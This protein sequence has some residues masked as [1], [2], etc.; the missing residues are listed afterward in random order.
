MASCESGRYADH[1]GIMVCFCGAFSL[2]ASI[3]LKVPT[4]L[5][6]ISSLSRII[7]SGVRGVLI[8]VD[9]NSGPELHPGFPVK[10]NHLVDE[11][12][13]KASCSGWLSG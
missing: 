7:L 2:S 12:M 6:M 9:G 1:Y 10:T 4:S 5:E 8:I 13:P 11:F 3:Y